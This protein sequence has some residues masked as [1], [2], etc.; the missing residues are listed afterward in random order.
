MGG[1]GAEGSC[2]GIRAIA[3]C[4]LNAKT[5][6]PFGSQAP[7]GGLKTLRGSVIRRA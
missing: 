5:G 1:D 3:Y 7:K 6:S 2:M 4:E